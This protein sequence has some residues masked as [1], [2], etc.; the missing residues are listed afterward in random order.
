MAP[1]QASTRPR[2]TKPAVPPR[3]APLADSATMGDLLK[4]LGNIPAARVRLASVSGHRNREG[5]PPGSR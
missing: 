4:R 5:R 2:K 3:P 1:T